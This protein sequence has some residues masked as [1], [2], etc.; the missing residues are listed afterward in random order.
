MLFGT[1]RR[2]RRREIF[3]AGF[4]DDWRDLCRGRFDWWDVLDDGE[5]ER[6]ELVALGLVA[7][8]EWEPAQG[9]TITEEM[10]VLIAAQAGLITSN[11]PYEDPYRDVR[12]VIVH[13]TTA[14]M[15]GEH[16]QVDGVY[17]DD[18]TP[19]LGE[20]VLH[21][22]VLVAWDEVQDDVHHAG[23]GRNV[24]YHEFAH[25]LDMLDGVTDGTPPMSAELAE[26]WVPVC[27]EVYEAVVEG[28][29]GHVLDD[30]AGVNPSEF[31]AVATEAFFDDPVP[32]RREHPDLYG[33]F[34]D[35]Y[36]HDPATWFVD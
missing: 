8:A 4:R 9:F 20:A 19:I 26:R 13:P 10:Q 29:A 35:F 33:C 36:G 16:S 32:L 27:T 6:V 24:V 18:P 14:I 31:F 12:A 21:G 34:V 7:T 11:L 23:D 1:K 2:R 17:S 5:R 15:H 3:D 30:Y 25:K 28:R 22:P